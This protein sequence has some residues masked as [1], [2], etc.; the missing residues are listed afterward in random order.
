MISYRPSEWLNTLES[1]R[2]ENPITCRGSEFFFDN[3]NSMRFR[4]QGAY[5]N[6]YAYAYEV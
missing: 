4:D 6:A 5:R 2:I 1:E 3:K